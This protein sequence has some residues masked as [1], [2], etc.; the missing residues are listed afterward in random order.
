LIVL[1]LKT[2]VSQRLLV[3]LKQNVSASV[4]L[5]E[6]VSN[7]RLQSVLAKRLSVVRTSVVLMRSWSVSAS[8]IVT[9]TVVRSS[10][11]VP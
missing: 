8:E 7:D 6:I 2:V 4:R 11:V 1:L 10:K 3:V 5:N 9:T